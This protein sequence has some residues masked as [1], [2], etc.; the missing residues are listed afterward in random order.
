MSELDIVTM[1][2]SCHLC[3]PPPSMFSSAAFI[4]YGLWSFSLS[5]QWSRR[6]VNY[7]VFPFEPFVKAAVKVK[8]RKVDFRVPA[9]AEAASAARRRCRATP[10][11]FAGW[12]WLLYEDGKSFLFL[13]VAENRRT[14][15]W[16]SWWTVP[17]EPIFL[18]LRK[19]YQRGGRQKCFSAL[20][21]TLLW[22][23]ALFG[24][25]P[26]LWAW[27]IAH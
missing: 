27:I 26:R 24:K 13:K 5:R 23:L 2:S 21:P 17:L 4:S 3:T 16:Q 8:D 20:S 12:W 15:S 1:F 22:K 9:S 25:S 14:R 11:A 7:C 10:T 18:L 19:K 6:R